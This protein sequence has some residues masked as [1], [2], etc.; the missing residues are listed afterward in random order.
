MG[1]LLLQRTYWQIV[2]GRRQRE[3]AAVRREGKKNKNKNNG[4]F[5]ERKKETIHGKQRKEEQKG[6]KEE[7]NKKEEQRRE[8]PAFARRRMKGGGGREDIEEGEVKFSFVKTQCQNH[9]TR[10]KDTKKNWVSKHRCQN[11]KEGRKETELQTPPF[12]PQSPSSAVK[13]SGARCPSTPGGHTRTSWCLQNLTPG[14]PNH[15]NCC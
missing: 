9:T 5:K 1:L 14:H 8:A 12:R 10:Q 6:E 13:G 7:T 15:R 11:L 4:Q 3:Q 2:C